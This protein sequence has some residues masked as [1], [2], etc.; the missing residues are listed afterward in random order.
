MSLTVSYHK[1][2]TLGSFGGIGELTVEPVETTLET[3]GTAT[4]LIKNFSKPVL[5]VN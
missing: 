2:P 3:V 4:L 1:S 5:Y